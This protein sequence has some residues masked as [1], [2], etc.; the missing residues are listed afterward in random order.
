MA[1]ISTAV[2]ARA[3]SSGSPCASPINRKIIPTTTGNINTSAPGFSIF[4][5]ECWATIDTHCCRGGC[6]EL[7]LRSKIDWPPS[8][9]FPPKTNVKL[10]PLFACPTRNCRAFHPRVAWPILHSYYSTSKHRDSLDNLVVWVFFPIENP[11]AIAQ[12]ATHLCYNLHVEEGGQENLT[13]E[14]ETCI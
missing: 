8:W 13:Y 14:I 1:K 4:R 11:G 9:V 12:L 2:T 5:S 7:V 3:P 10:V 6:S